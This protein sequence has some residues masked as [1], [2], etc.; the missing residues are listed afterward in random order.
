MDPDRGESIVQYIRAREIN[1]RIRAGVS[2][3]YGLHDVTRMF[4][5]LMSMVCENTISIRVLADSQYKVKV[6]YDNPGI[7][8]DQPNEILVTASGHRKRIGYYANGEQVTEYQ[9]AIGG[10][11][12]DGEIMPMEHTP[13]V[14]TAAPQTLMFASGGL[15]VPVEVDSHAMQHIQNMRTIPSTFE[16]VVVEMSAYTI[17]RA[18]TSRVTVNRRGSLNVYAGHV[19]FGYGASTHEFDL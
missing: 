5:F 16:E 18:N 17:S 10:R 1:P 3:F 13:V 7:Q 8:S 6:I 19:S 14:P 15:S 11:V 9:T 2:W 12:F 4:Q